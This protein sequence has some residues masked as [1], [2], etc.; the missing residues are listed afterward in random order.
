MFARLTHFTDRLGA[1]IAA[2]PL[3][4][5][6]GVGVALALVLA[7]TV[8]RYLGKIAEQD[9]QGKYTKSA[10]LRWRPQLEDLDRGVD[11]YDK[12]RYPNPPI[13]ALVLKPFM[14]LPPTA[15]AVTWLLLK[16]AMAGVMFVWAV[17]LAA[18]PG[19]RFPTLAAAAV[20]LLSLHPILGDLQ[21]GNVN[22]FISFL[23]FA[24]LELFR[25]GWDVTAGVVLAL[26]IACKVTPALF[27][28]YFGWKAVHGGWSAWRA[29][30]V[31]VRDVWESGG[32]VLVG[33]LAGL[34]LWLGA[35]PGLF[36][37]F[38]RNATLLQSWYGTMV[39]PFVQGKVQAE[40][41][42]QSLPGV[43]HGFFTGVPLPEEENAEN[44]GKS[45]KRRGTLVDLGPPAASWMVRGCQ[46]LFML[47]VVLL[48]RAPAVGT[49]H[50]VRVAAE[51]AFI[52][53]GMLLFSERT[54]KHHATTTLLPFAAVIGFWVFH[55][56]T[57]VVR[58]AV[59]ALMVAATVLMSGPSLLPDKWQEEC[60][61]AGT[62]AWAFVLLTSAVGVVMWQA[63][64]SI[65]PI[66]S[67]P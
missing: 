1:L 51:F 13:M 62:H 14:A 49:R 32:K 10:F 16:A 29:K 58:T 64:R 38:E 65:R 9:H 11:I 26:A 63:G 30:R 57:G 48:A 31:I 19:R 12:Y 54:W 8:G 2:R 17:R 6:V 56:P 46:G 60:L 34:A 15:G 61:E 59:F 4:W 21:H 24:S 44:D 20:G 35:V 66:T 50:G 52:A 5:R 37:G 67:S 55:R 18:E 28:V 22:V 39:Q 42:N 33:C 27:V 43:A 41:A 45:S 36:L 53:L 47:A 23:L 3:M 7:V 25:R 40:I